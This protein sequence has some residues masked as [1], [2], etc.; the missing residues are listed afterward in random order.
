MGRNDEKSWIRST[1]HSLKFKCS[2]QLLKPFFLFFSFTFCWRPIFVAQI[3]FIYK[4]QVFLFFCSLFFLL[5]Q[6]FL[7]EKN[8][9]K[10]PPLPPP[11]HY[12]PQFDINISFALFHLLMNW[13]NTFPLNS[14][15]STF[16]FFLILP[17]MFNILTHYITPIP[18]SSCNKYIKQIQNLPYST[19]SLNEKTKM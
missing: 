14:I 1:S 15:Y 13:V 17:F 4:K 5:P 11:P 6:L 10:T 9:Y 7:P 2:P 8:T 12:D 16:Y 19:W 3:I 18:F